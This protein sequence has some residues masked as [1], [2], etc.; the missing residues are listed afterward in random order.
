MNRINGFAVGVCV[1]LLS[2]PM[3]GQAWVPCSQGYCGVITPAGSCSTNLG[4]TFEEATTSCPGT[5]C[6]SITFNRFACN[7]GTEDGGVVKETKPSS[8]LADWHRVRMGGTSFI[9]AL[10]DPVPQ[11]NFIVSHDQ[12]A[13]R[14]ERECRCELDEAAQ[15][16]R[17]KTNAMAAWTDFNWISDFVSNG[18]PCGYVD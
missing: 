4:M 8:T 3:N 1:M 7:D 2:S 11:G 9:Q 18:M 14:Q 10:F 13:C 12:F 5:G 17:C 15:Q 16:Q 6:I